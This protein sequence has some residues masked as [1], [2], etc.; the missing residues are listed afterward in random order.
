MRVCVYIYLYVCMYVYTL[1]IYTHTHTHSHIYIYTYACHA[2]FH[3]LILVY[4]SRSLFADTCLCCD[5]SALIQTSFQHRL[6]FA[7]LSH[8]HVNSTHGQTTTAASGQQHA[9]HAGISRRIYTHVRTNTHIHTH[10]Y[11]ITY[12]RI[13]IDACIIYTHV[14]IYGCVQ[15]YTHTSTL[16]TIP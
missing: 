10:I 12:K 7:S 1:Y 14:G 2:H 16:Q 4:T 15:I 9:S 11:N 13:C 8:R 3:V 5:S 6:T